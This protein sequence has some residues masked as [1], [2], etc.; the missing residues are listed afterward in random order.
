MSSSR[1]ST[2]WRHPHILLAVFIT[3]LTCTNMARAHN[4]TVFAWIDGNTVHV[5]SKFAGGRT[6]K[7]APIEVFDAAGNLLL[8]GKTD[9]NGEF[10]FRVPQ[11]TAMKI[12]LKAG[13][14]HRAEWTIPLEEF[15]DVAAAPAAETAETG[16]SAAPA[17]G[18]AGKPTPASHATGLTE[19]ELQQ[20]L[21]KALDKK[22]KPLMK[23]VAESKAS[24]PSMNEIIGGIGY[25]LGL[26]GIG[27]YFHARRSQGPAK[28]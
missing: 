11:K 1:L 13:M 22:L 15:G 28:K 12:V 19:A 8:Q 7:S 14:G 18:A 27:A 3:M 2:G 6:P 21:E 20:A 24:G 5:E 25:I 26:V 10:S 17:G 16:P 9:E 23:L 4:V